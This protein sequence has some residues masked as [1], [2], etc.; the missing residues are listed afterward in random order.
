MRRPIA[1]LV[2]LV[3]DANIPPAVGAVAADNDAMRFEIALV[4]PG[5]VEQDAC[6]FNQLDPGR[7]R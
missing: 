6:K 2:H 7:G 5:H 4:V 1:R 3:L